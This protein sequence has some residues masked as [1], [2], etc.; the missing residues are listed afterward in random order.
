MLI[1]PAAELGLDASRR[2]PVAFQ[3]QRAQREGAAGRVMLGMPF[4]VVEASPNE[5][6]IAAILQRQKRDRR[7]RN[8]GRQIVDEDG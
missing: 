4:E 2:A 6:L 1:E 5:R 3:R 8:V 7:R